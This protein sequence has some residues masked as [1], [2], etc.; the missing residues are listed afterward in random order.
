MA[1]IVLFYGVADAQ[2]A[3]VDAAFQGHFGENDDFEPLDGVRELERA[4]QSGSRE[5]TFYTY[6]NMQHWFFEDDRPEYDREAAGLAWQ[7]T[8]AFLRESFRTV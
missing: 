3:P 8:I 5:V 6:P 1:A 4:L 7:R 2:G